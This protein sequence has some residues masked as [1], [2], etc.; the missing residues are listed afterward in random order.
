MPIKE[1]IQYDL[2]P[3]AF[4]KGVYWLTLR[5]KNLGNS[6][7]TDLDV[8]LNS[9]D[10]YSIRIFDTGS[11]VPQIDSGEEEV[12]HLQASVQSTAEVY[13]SLDGRRNGEPFH[14]ESAGI[15][16]VVDEQPAELVSLF[17]LTEPHAML[18][19]PITCE[20]T[21]RG[22]T[23]TVSLVLEFWVETPRGELRSL[24]KEGVGKLAEGQE[25]RYRFEITPDEGGIYILHA[26]LY[27]GA[28]RIG[29][30]V[31]YLSIAL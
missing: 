3:R 14:W 4:T 26:Y 2:A 9:L 21:V 18:G 16:L 11:F 15:R 31:E 6:T 22:L 20:A 27:E 1:F 17:A 10:T 28:W 19:E 29:H 24:A 12:R 25:R 23:A 5:L 8:R 30:Q 13:A 7:L